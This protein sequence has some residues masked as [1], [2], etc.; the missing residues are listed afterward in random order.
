MAYN[1]DPRTPGVDPR[2]P[3]Q[4]NTHVNTP[5]PSGRSTSSMA[6][7]VGGVVVAVI[8][9]YLVFSGMFGSNQ[10]TSSGPAPTGSSS[11]VNIEAPAAPTAPTNVA[12]ADPVAPVAPADPVAPAAPAPAETVAPAP[13]D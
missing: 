1:S 10:S 3:N 7:I 6:F 9:L 4:T 11:S 2:V 8:V 5:V 13:A 12:P